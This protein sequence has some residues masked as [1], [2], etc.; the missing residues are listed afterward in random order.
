MKILFS[1]SLSYRFA[2][3]AVVVS[4]MASL[5]VTLMLIAAD[6]QLAKS[7]I[8]EDTRALL[9]SGSQT[10]RLAVYNLDQDMTQTIVNGLVDYPAIVYAV[11]VD[12][13]GKILARS[14]RT[15][16]LSRYRWIS[17]G[18]IGNNVTLQQ[19]LKMPDSHTFLGY[20]LIEIDSFILGKRFLQRASLLFVGS[21]LLAGL[22][23]LL[24]I[25]LHRR[26]LT[27][28]LQSMLARLDEIDPKAPEDQ[29]LEYPLQHDRDEV[30][31]LVEQINK[32]L[33]S[34]TSHASRRERAESDLRKNLSSVEFIVTER[35]EALRS[36][37][38]RLQTQLQAQQQQLTQQ[39]Q[40][41]HHA[42]QQQQRLES[43]LLLRLQLMQAPLKQL[44]AAHSP[45]LR[46][47]LRDSL[48][49]Q[50][51]QNCQHIQH[52]LLP[53]AHA[54]SVWLSDALELMTRNLAMHL[55]EQM[56]ELHCSFENPL[57]ALWRVKLMDVLWLAEQ[58]TLRIAEQAPASDSPQQLHLRGRLNVK[59]QADTPHLQIT[60]HL[61]DSNT[62]LQPLMQTLLDGHDDD[63]AQLCQTLH[64]VGASLRLST[65][66]A[67]R[68]RLLMPLQA[69]P[70]P[71]LKDWSAALPS[72]KLLLIWC[73]QADALRHLHN[74]LRGLQI[75]FD[76]LQIEADAPLADNIEPLA[77]A[78]Y[79]GCITNHAP[80]AQRL[81]QQTQLRI[82][83]FQ[84]IEQS[85]DHTYLSF[86]LRQQESLQLLLS[87]MHAPTLPTR[88]WLIIDN[89]PIH[90]AMIRAQLLHAGQMCFIAADETAAFDHLQA[91]RIGKL[92]INPL[93][94]SDTFVD[95]LLAS[96]TT[97]SIDIYWLGKA[98][99]GSTENYWPLPFTI[100]QFENSGSTQ[101]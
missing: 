62:S 63:S 9:Q 68:L 17:D 73:E 89:H 37:S 86:P 8:F 55:R 46:E 27:R 34:V 3:Q 30:G 90:Q 52:L 44:A 93:C 51:Q 19:E 15:P 81:R 85:V 4:V 72:G 87:W 26:Y 39:Q 97:S 64:Q 14:R 58:I 47:L 25:L 24:L 99:E 60:W 28:P 101:M 76:T 78:A 65:K 82:A 43:Q 11:I 74:T 57:A 18:L 71:N 53:S 32:L 83:Q 33:L 5:L 20:L 66:H 56:I 49:D 84:A 61:S 16:Q 40:Q 94:V 41:H 6:Y 48:R 21:M 80:I 29:R 59:H 7:Q 38:Q 98:P 2:S 91:Q 45:L 10:S 36:T 23:T 31:V 100:K 92:L 69:V 79:L 1:E 12:N 95:D 22:I 70:G 50:L 96:P 42:E 75:A 35:T 88:S 54:S 67:D 77:R 13:N